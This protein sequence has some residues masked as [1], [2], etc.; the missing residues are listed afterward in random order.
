MNNVLMRSLPMV[1][2]VLGNKYGVKVEI[3][4][5]SAYTDGHTIHLPGLPAEVNKDTLGLV[6]GFLDHESAHIRETDF[7]VLKN[8]TIKPIT[9]S[10]WNIIEDWRV[11]NVLS[12]RFPGCRANFDWLIENQFKEPPEPQT[13]VAIEI[14][15]YILYCV[16]SWD[17]S[18]LGHIK[19]Q[20]GRSVQ[21]QFPKLFRELNVL[22]D[23]VRSDCHSTV[24]ALDHAKGIVKLI[25]RHAKGDDKQPKQKE[26]D[27][28]SNS[29]GD[30]E[31]SPGSKAKDQKTSEK[32]NDQKH[33]ESDSVCSSTVNL[34]SGDLV[35]QNAGELGNKSTQLTKLLEM[36]ESELPDDLG[37]SLSTQLNELKAQSGSQLS[38]AVE[39]V[40]HAA[41]LDSEVLNKV[42]RSSVAMH[43]KLCSLLQS[44]VMKR[45]RPSRSG[46]LNPNRL[47]RMS[48]DTKLF[49]RHELKQGVNS[50]IHILLDCS[51]SMRN[52]IDLA[53]ETCFSMANSLSKINGVKVAVSAF[54]ADSGNSKAARNGVCDTIFPLLKYGESIHGRFKLKASGS[55]PMGASIWWALQNEP[56]VKETR[57]IMLIITDGRPDCMPNTEEAIKHGKQ[58]G[59]EFYGIGIKDT[60]IKNILPDHHKVIT[61]LDELA[62]AMFGMLESALLN[63]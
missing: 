53:T 11:E 12:K 34:D 41:P 18:S 9:K 59:F 42:K 47:A 38:I 49:K 40:K 43:T 5:S 32:T 33:A 55:T 15:N 17:V 22:L 26:M 25:K 19:D 39:G 27:H 46:K 16:R 7:R 8:K 45:S 10:I 44:S 24:D 21:N 52:Q 54:P 4:G 51:G 6:R 2:A 20:V 28:D 29:T 50:N 48:F 1:A 3:G 14:V 63:N 56:M 36:S 60:Y 58:L 35:D 31:R 37:S 13:D 62:P 30:P 23:K 57:K 61:T